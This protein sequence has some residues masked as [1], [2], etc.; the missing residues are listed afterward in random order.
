MFYLLEGGSLYE[1]KRHVHIKKVIVS[2]VASCLNW[3]IFSLR[4]VAM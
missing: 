2:S 3:K 4:V 1:E